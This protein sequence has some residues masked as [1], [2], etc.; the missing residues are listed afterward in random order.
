MGFDSLKGLAKVVYTIIALFVLCIGSGGYFYGRH[1]MSKYKEKWEAGAKNEPFW[2]E[3][4]VGKKITEVKWKDAAVNSLVL[5]SGE[6][7]FIYK[8]ENGFATLMIKD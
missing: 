5:D 7:V 4:L 2:K 3:V 6:E 8:N 1:S